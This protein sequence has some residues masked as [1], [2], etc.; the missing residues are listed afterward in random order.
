MD[1]KC[2]RGIMQN[3]YGIKAEKLEKSE[4]STDGNVFIVIGEHKKYIMKVYSNKKHVFE[5]V[6]LHNYLNSKK[7]NLPIIITSKNGRKYIT[8]GGYYYILYSFIEGTKLKD[9]D[10]DR[11]RIENI[12]NYLRR[13]HK[14]SENVVN[15]SSIPFD[16][17][18]ER[19]SILHFD[20]TKN[21]IFEN[22]GE[23]IFIDFDDAK[24]GPSICDVAIAITNLFISKNNGADV[25]KMLYFLDCY[26]YREEQLRNEEVPLI[27]KVAVSWL[28][29]IMQNNNFSTS[30]KSGL[31]S[32][33]YW[34]NEI[35]LF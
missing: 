5:M 15:K 9:L 3:E 24:Y 7:I 12:A 29:L 14:L 8:E 18:S 22:N 33:L 30:T 10:F 11:K 16:V 23:I 20:I 21:N 31:E 4:E 1:M 34:I 19:K 27:K 28:N 2:I 13:L 26:Y 35:K 17:Y 25:K 32:K 6:N